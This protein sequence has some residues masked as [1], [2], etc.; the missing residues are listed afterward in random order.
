MLAHAFLV[1]TTTAAR[2]ADTAATT[3]ITL[4][5]NKFRPLFDAL[6][7]RSLHTVADILA[8]SQWRRKHHGWINRISGQ[9]GMRE[10]N[11][12]VL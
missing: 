1:V 5:V 8:W 6:L 7:L 4:T 2:L 10:I 11:V 12:V 9:L 3:L